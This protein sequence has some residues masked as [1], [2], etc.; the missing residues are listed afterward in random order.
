MK[1]RGF[2]GAAAAAWPGL[3][4]VAAAQPTGP[5]R[6][7]TFVLVHGAWHGGWC[8][9]RVAQRLRAQ[10]H[11]VYTPT[12][13]GLADRRHL[14]SPQVNLD[15]HVQDI[16]LLLEH[17]ELADVVLVGH[18]Y[19]GIVISGVADRMPG[20]LR[21][22]VY[23]DALLLESGRSIF[24]SFSK[25]VVAQRLR[26]IRETGAGVG[27]VA[28]FP[29]SAFGVH[30][31]ADAAWVARRLTPQPVGTYL[32]PLVLES[33][34]G[35]GIAKT[36]IDCTREPMANLA[37]GKTRVRD[38]RSWTLRSLDA[39]HDAMVTAP[40]ELAALLAEIAA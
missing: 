35:N 2:V 8:W 36:Y 9:A 29:P 1:R 20:P 40:S 11:V 3:P 18:S 24:S 30:D 28:A 33:P 12:L 7:R 15:T 27:A 37:A 10:G 22:L 6:K 19:A 26:A 32:Q 34:L 17:E 23:L 31:A 25:D 39:G 21:H 4:L 14:L 38:D 16:T 5:A 13:T